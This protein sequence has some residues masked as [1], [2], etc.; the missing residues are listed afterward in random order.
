MCEHFFD[1]S[2]ILQNDELGTSNLTQSKTL[3]RPVDS[4]GAGGARVPPEL[5][6]SEK[7]TEREIDK[8]IT[9]SI[10]G[11]EKPSTALTPDVL[12]N[13]PKSKVHWVSDFFNLMWPEQS[14]K[15]SSPNYLSGI[16]RGFCSIF[17]QYLLIFLVMTA[18]LISSRF[19]V[20]IISFCYDSENLIYIFLTN[21]FYKGS[22]NL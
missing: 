7:T 17:V 19:A 8:S 9:T 13:L 18:C 4:G 5:G 14:Q 12:T 3:S 2:A 22:K 16:Q 15:K 20:S 11:F 6:G 10:P 21:L 1:F